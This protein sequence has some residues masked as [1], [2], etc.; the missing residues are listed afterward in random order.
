[1]LPKLKHAATL[2]LAVLALI[3]V[4]LFAG[5]AVRLWTA[6][7]WVDVKTP[8]YT[9]K[10]PKAPTRAVQI[11]PDP[12]AGARMN[13]YRVEVDG[14][15]YQLDEIETNASE[16]MSA[17]L[18]RFVAATSAALGG[19]LNPQSCPAD[20][21]IQLG[22]GSEVRGRMYASRD[23]GRIFRLLVA[24]PAAVVADSPDVTLFLDSFAPLE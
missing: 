24:K 21:R 16:V 1:M 5:L 11:A 20:F 17:D 10:F 22:D 12:W 6:P 3:L 14:A 13:T 19:T 23:Q 18:A 15:T 2:T 4:G 9:I 7:A 8:G